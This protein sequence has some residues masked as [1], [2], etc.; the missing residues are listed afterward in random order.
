[1]SLRPREHDA[2]SM[3][4]CSTSRSEL[5]ERWRV[6][7]E[8]LRKRSP[9]VFEKVI[10]MLATSDRDEDDDERL[11]IDEIYRLH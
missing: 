3:A 5:A 10:E 2:R 1:M 6:A 8:R 7:G 4:G 11:D 9:R